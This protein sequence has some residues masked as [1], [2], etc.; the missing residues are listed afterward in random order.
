MEGRSLPRLQV[1]SDVSENYVNRLEN[2]NG[3]GQ[4]TVVP[5]R[6]H[7][8]NSLLYLTFVDLA[9]AETMARSHDGQVNQAGVKTNMGLQ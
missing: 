1:L 7:Q 5:L 4:S 8:I 6:F 9:G 2:C 3:G